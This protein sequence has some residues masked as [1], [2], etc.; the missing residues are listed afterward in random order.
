MIVIGGGPA[1][2]AAG[3]RAARG[4]ASVTVFEKAGRDELEPTHFLDLQ[5]DVIERELERQKIHGSGPAAE[6]IL[7]DL[8]VVK[9]AKTG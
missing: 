2:A 6:N 1:G 5:T 4:G 3:I 7:R 8:G 9:V